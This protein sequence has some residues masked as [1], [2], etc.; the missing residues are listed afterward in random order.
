MI[1]FLRKGLSSWFLLGILGLV[2]AAFIITGVQD[3]FGGGGGGNT[4]ATVA[5]I[6]KTAVG[7]QTV[8]EELQ[9]RVR[10]I[11]QENK[12]VTMEQVIE[13][14]GLKTVVDGL[15]GKIALEKMLESIGIAGGQKSVDDIIAKEQAFQLGG[16]FSKKL[17]EDQLRSQRLTPKQYEQQLSMDVARA[18]ILGALSRG[19]V[20]PESVLLTYADQLEERRAIHLVAVPASAMGAPPIPD[21]KA[22][23]AFYEK[24]K[25][26]F[27]APELRSFRYIRLDPSVMLS[28]ITVTDKDIADY[29]KENAGTL[30][31]AEKRDLLRITL[32]SKEK[33]Q[34]FAASARSGDFVA[35]AKKV[36]PAL[37]EEDINLKGATQKDV[38]VD[39]G[40]DAAAKI[41]KL[42]RGGV[43]DPLETTFGWQVVKVGSIIAGSGPTLDATTKA[44]A[45]EEIRKRKSVDAL[46]D[47]TP[48]LDDALEKRRSFDDVA[49]MAMVVPEAVD[50]IGSNGNAVDGKAHLKSVSLGS[51]LQLA[52]NHRPGDEL[53]LESVGEDSYALVEVTK[54]TPPAARSYDSIKPVLSLLWQRDQ[55]NI[56]AKAQADT[57]LKKIASGQ[58]VAQAA[59]RYPNQ[60]L[61]IRRADLAQPNV[62]IPPVIDKAFKAKLGEVVLS[63][64][65]G[66]NGFEL[67][68]VEKIEPGK[69]T[70][71]SDTFRGLASA[72]VRYGSMEPQAQFIE[73]A[74]QQAGTQTNAAAID[75]LRRQMLGKE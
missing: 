2:L 73:A 29:V 71:N 61:P 49:K 34:A 38:A 1:S 15:V 60:L 67:A 19:W 63:P 25:A 64:S 54:V 14:G 17:Y 30:G 57:L 59:G 58:S 51:V 35:L 3:P 31:K 20:L 18:Q 27:R 46:Y 36:D 22:L 69:A 48:K 43:S 24:N 42:A 74:R 55:L 62:Q 53:L 12:D 44:T 4:G 11:Q 41:F 6:G 65:L 16:Q 21:E 5:N 66:G 23:R 9:N 26:Q 28:R 52:F 70:K 45:T 13:S 7:A 40:D 39:T 32:D 68:K 50:A 33:A 56:K 75:K 47:L 8:Q 37:T 72:V 10:V